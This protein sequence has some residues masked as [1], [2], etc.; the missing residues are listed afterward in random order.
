MDG[1]TD[2]DYNN[3]SVTHTAV[4]AKE[5]W[6][7]VD[8]GASAAIGDIEVY[9]RTGGFGDRLT[10]YWVIVSENPIT[11]QDLATARTGPGVTA[12][13]QPDEAGTPT[14]V[15]FAGAPGRYVR[16]QLENQSGP[17][18]LAEVCVYKH[19]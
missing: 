12:K 9:N 1:N 11:A 17:L 6:W 18:S 8:L 13:R 14:T 7:Q 15:N 10:N 5:A 19:P 4:D 2:G 16:I 3:N